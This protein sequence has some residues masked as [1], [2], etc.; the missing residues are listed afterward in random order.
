MKGRWGLVALGV[1]ALVVALLAVNTICADTETRSAKADVGKIV[2]MPGGDLQ[3]LD[4]GPREAPA[5]I[6]LHGFAESI[7]WWDEVADSLAKDHRVLT[8][9]LLGHGGSEKPRTGY[10]IP[11]QAGLVLL[12]SRKL[13]VDRA[14]VVGQS[15]GGVVALSLAEQ[16]RSFVQG[17][18]SIASPPDNDSG[19]LPFLAQLGF[20]PVLGQTI[21]TLA[22]DS[23]V[24]EGLKGAFSD[25]YEVPDEFVDDFYDMTYSSYDEAHDAG[26]DYFDDGDAPERL[27][28]LG[29]IPLL[30]I[31][32]EK[33]EIVEPS[34]IEKWKDV[35]NARTIVVEG[36]GHS[37]M[38]EKPSETARLISEFDKQV[39]RTGD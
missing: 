25:G 31:Y 22:N 21:K 19:E 18:V 29:A 5:I 14:L 24:K 23:L 32:G 15:M 16:A 27:S 1:L 26:A 13:G 30:V 36:V 9:D 11:S 4:Q 3:V 6:L 20:V 33:D 37:V 39:R 2:R 8:F 28:K 7:R 34:S 12:A 38:V 35:D 17:I 10:S